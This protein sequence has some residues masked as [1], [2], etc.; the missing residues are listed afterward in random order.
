MGEVRSWGQGVDLRGFDVPQTR[1]DKGLLLASRINEALPA[2]FHNL[3]I[4]LLP[5]IMFCFV[6]KTKSPIPR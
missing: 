1:G 3:T 4:T 2:L 6:F 5:E